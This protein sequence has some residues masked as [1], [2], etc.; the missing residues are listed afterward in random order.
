MPA[1]SPRR[2]LVLV[3][4][5]AFVI[6]L[7]QIGLVSIAF[8]KLGLSRES[9]YLLLMLTLA[10][11]MIN[12]PVV[13]LKADGPPPPP[14]PESSGR[15]PFPRFPPFTGKVTI[16]VNIGGAVV[17]VLFSLYLF[18]HTPL[19]IFRSA[20]SIMVVAWASSTF[21]RPI[22]R[23]GIGMPVLIAPLTAA[24]AASLLDPV[25]RAP[26]AYVSGTLGVLIGA[27]LMRLKDILRLGSPVASIGGAG[28]LDGVFLTGL[29]AVLLA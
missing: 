3:L 28:T 13:T 20:A 19:E 5:L 7:I 14:M 10:G 11:S 23:I 1:P 8:D 26:L 15:W 24:V 27:D 29:I 4:V 22:P 25:Q 21:S 16:F 2:L 17:P 18:A 6:G 9:T 12:V